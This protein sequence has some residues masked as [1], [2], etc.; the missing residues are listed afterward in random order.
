MD[1]GLGCKHVSLNLL[2]ITPLIVEGS[3]VQLN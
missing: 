1:T 2:G 3:P